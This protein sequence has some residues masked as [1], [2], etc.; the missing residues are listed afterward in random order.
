MAAPIRSDGRDPKGDGVCRILVVDD[1]PFVLRMAERFLSRSG[2]RV[3]AVE[4]GAEALEQL[5][6]VGRRIDVLLTDLRM[7]NMPG[8]V[9]AHRARREW[10]HLKV[11]YMSSEIE[12]DP[13]LW[14]HDEESH[15][16]RKPF[17]P[18]DLLAVVSRA[19]AAPG[20]ELS[21]EAGKL[22]NR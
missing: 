11:V 7:P 21:A 15:A 3:L 5:Q 12:L 18:S 16:I 17:R 9:L 13:R 1:E 4:S 8:W 20:I 2:Y 6:A 14:S 10:P 22:G 19:V